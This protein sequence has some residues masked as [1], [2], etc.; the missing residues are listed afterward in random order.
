[1]KILEQ[2]IK[3]V[4]SKEQLNVLSPARHR[5]CLRLSVAIRRVGQFETEELN[6]AINFSFTHLLC[7]LFDIKYSYHAKL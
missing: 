4:F 6:P 7:H 1:M 2:A 3:F 5:L